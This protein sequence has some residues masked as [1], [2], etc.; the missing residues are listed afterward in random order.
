MGRLVVVSNRTLC[1]EDNDVAGGLA[2]GVLSALRKKGGLW[3]GWS[4]KV[5]R[6]DTQQVKRRKF[7]NI[8]YKTFDL[9]KDDYQQY[10]LGFCNSALWPL[11]HFF[12]NQVKFQQTEYQRYLKVNHLF[13]KHLIGE[14]KTD[15]MLWVHDY[16]F[17]PLARNLRVMGCRQKIGLFLHV[18]FPSFQVFRTLPVWK[19]LLEYLC[20]F[21]VIG[22]QTQNDRQSFMECVE[23]GLSLPVVANEIFFNKK[24]V[25]TAVIPI[26]IDCQHVD[27]LCASSHNDEQVKALQ[28][29]L[30]QADPRKLI[31]GADRLDYSK[32]LLERMQGYKCMLDSFPEMQRKAV[33]LQISQPSRI[34][35]DDYQE[36]KRHLQNTAGAINAEYGTIDW[37]PIRYV[38]SGYTQ[39]LLFQFFRLSHVGL[40]TSLRDG[41]NLVAKE[42]VAA[43][44]TI[45][46]GVLVLSEFTG[47]AEELA[48]AIL[49]NPYDQQS[50]ANGLRQALNMSILE[51]QLRHQTMIKR[52]KKNSV[53][54]WANSFISFLSNSDKVAVFTDTTDDKLLRAKRKSPLILKPSVNVTPLTYYSS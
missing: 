24:V 54:I 28:Q 39:S 30:K 32:G 9:C 33:M 12:L 49:V 25:K 44:N 11:L 8:D 18:P 20:E 37:T 45:D 7:D 51:R 1:P 21:D 14:L 43:Q 6:D 40:I 27:E 36:M 50:I 10:Y 35:I 13:A 17:M 2:V 4:G 34:E 42:Y 26:G 19:Q 41:M 46:P 29:S 31:I 3:F 53:H 38:N 5:T 52:L 48:E 22:F 16:H 47:A 15:D 23:N